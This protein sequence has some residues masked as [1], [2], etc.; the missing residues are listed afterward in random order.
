[1]CCHAL[2]GPE[3]GRVPLPPEMQ[4]CCPP[5]HPTSHAHIAWKTHRPGK[6]AAFTQALPLPWER[7]LKLV[8]F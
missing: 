2:P 4:P 1:M 6:C 3:L 5:S 7:W 8:I